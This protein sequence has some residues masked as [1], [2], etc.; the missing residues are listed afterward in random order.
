LA[1][2][3]TLQDNE[4]MINLLRSVFQGGYIFKRVVAP[5]DTI[6]TGKAL[7]KPISESKS[8]YIESGSYILNKAVQDCFQKQYYLW[9][10]SQLRIEK[11]DGIL[12][13]QFHIP[14]VNNFPIVL[15]HR[16]V[17]KM[18]NYNITIKLF[19][20]DFFQTIYEITGPKKNSIIKTDFVRWGAGY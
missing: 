5:T 19:S 1:L 20:L 9:K 15:E 18:D 4:Q 13:H 11:R 10:N 3:R 7:F 6:I 14:L 17:C 16:H 12:L 8:E 2:L